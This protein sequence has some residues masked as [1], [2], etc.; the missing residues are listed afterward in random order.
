VDRF[1]WIAAGA[2]MGANARFLVSIWAAERFGIAFPYGTLIVNVTGSLLLG[3]VIELT[4]A[5]LL[6]S[7]EMRLFIAT[8]F[9]GSYT[10]FSTYAVE[11]LLLIR[12]GNIWL[13]L[14][15]ILGSI[16]LGLL[17]ALLGIYLARLVGP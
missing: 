5:R 10:T 16:A 2:A 8:G 4:T 14:A 11:S 12:T 17:F 7:P 3:F 9:L 15:N 6:S 13:G 1:L